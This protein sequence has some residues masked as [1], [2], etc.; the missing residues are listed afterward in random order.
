MIPKFI[1]ILLVEL[2][3]LL[4]VPRESYAVPQTTV[5]GG[6]P[7][8]STSFLNYRKAKSMIPYRPQHI[9]GYLISEDL[10]YRIFAKDPNYYCYEPCFGICEPQRPLTPLFSHPEIAGFPGFLHPYASTFKVKSKCVWVFNLHIFSL[11]C[12]FSYSI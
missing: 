3:G 6:V 1:A 12:V 7:I 10:L 2:G 4:C 5:I 8:L 9:H 11:Y